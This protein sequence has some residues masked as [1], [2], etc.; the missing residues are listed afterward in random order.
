MQYVLTS[1]NQKEKKKLH[2]V[3]CLGKIDCN[4]ASCI[5]C[6]LNRAAILS[7]IYSLS[8]YLT[9]KWWFTNNQS[10]RLFSGLLKTSA[11]VDQI[12]SNPPQQ[13]LTCLRK[14]AVNRKGK[15]RGFTNLIIPL[16]DPGKCSAWFFSDVLGKCRKA[17]PAI[18]WESIM[19]LIEVL[20]F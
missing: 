3:S 14:P 2:R 5:S 13:V 12:K 1:C 11:L 15:L 20:V 10:V 9:T 17:A 4:L 6:S 19:K 16:A 18:N 7:C 8:A